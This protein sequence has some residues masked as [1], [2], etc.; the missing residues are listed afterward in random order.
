MLLCKMYKTTL[1]SM[2]QDILTSLQIGRLDVLFHTVLPLRAATGVSRIFP[3]CRGRGK[4]YKQKCIRAPELLSRDEIK[5]KHLVKQSRQTWL[6]NFRTNPHVL[7]CVASLFPPVN[8]AL[9][10]TVFI[11]WMFLNHSH[12]R[13]VFLLY[14]FHFVTRSSVLVLFQRFMFQNVRLVMLWLSV[15]VQFLLFFFFF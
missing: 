2:H 4:C 3:G 9:R 13:S 12:F 8:T 5:R 6:H 1:T 14:I 7:T 10:V 11:V 15:F